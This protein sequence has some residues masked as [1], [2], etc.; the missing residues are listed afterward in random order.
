MA[1]SKWAYGKLREIVDEEE[2]SGGRQAEESLC[3]VG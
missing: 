1:K 2:E 3:G